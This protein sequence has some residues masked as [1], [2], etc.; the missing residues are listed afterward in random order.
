MITIDYNQEGSRLDL[1]ILAV[2]PS[3]SKPVLLAL[4]RFLVGIYTYQCLHNHILR[5]HEFTL[6][7]CFNTFSLLETQE[8][9]IG[10][11]TL[12]APALRPPQALRVRGPDGIFSWH[13]ETTA[14]GVSGMMILAADSI[15]KVYRE[16]FSV[17]HQAI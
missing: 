9:P 11:A 8:Q 12:W 7:I 14:D 13:G 2:D 5:F 6:A 10:G 4:N 16:L 3:C 17:K 1:Y 15:T